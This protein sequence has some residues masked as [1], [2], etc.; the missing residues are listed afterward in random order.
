MLSDKQNPWNIQSFLER[1][2]KSHP[3]PGLLPA[4]GLPLAWNGFD[5]G[6]A[7]GIPVGTKGFVD[8]PE[9]RQAEKKNPNKQEFY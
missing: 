2:S 8:G 4:A 1:E 6:A 9:D 3:G 5:G 7:C